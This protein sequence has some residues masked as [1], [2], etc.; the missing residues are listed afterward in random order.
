MQGSRAVQ[1]VL[2]EGEPGILR[3]VLEAEGFHVVGQARGEAELRRVL[4]ATHPSVIVLDAGISAT[5]ALDAR[6]RAVGAQLVVVWPDGV[7]TNVAEERVDPAAALHDLGG[8]VRRAAERASG[9]DEQVVALPESPA[10]QPAMAVVRPLKPP[11]EDRPRRRSRRLLVVAA[12]VALALTASAAVGMWLPRTLGLFERRGTPRRPAAS[13]S[14]S[15]TEDP[16]STIAPAGND[17]PEPGSCR[18]SDR[19]GTAGTENRRPHEPGGCGDARAQASG[20]PDEQ[21]GHAEGKG[22]GEGEGRP[23]DPGGEDGGNGEVSGKGEDG[24]A[25]PNGKATGQASTNA[26]ASGAGGGG[27]NGPN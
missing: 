15:P 5:A 7:R 14:R 4:D 27:G 8:A 13:A 12:A 22:A 9:W 1:V 23:D 3:F 20:R 17:D 10:V 18:R 26:D 2:G 25:G 21:R 24:P 6:A 11:T 19:A 16:G